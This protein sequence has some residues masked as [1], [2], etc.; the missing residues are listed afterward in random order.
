[1]SARLAADG[2][3]VS[4]LHADRLIGYVAGEQDG[5]VTWEQ[6]EDIG[7]RRGAIEHR[8]RRG[9]LHARHPRVFSWGAWSDS[10]W[11]ASRAAVFAC[12]DG[13]FVSRHA[14]L[15]LYGIRP[16]P[17]GPVDVTVIGRRVRQ[18]G[19]AART[20][21]ALDRRDVRLVRSIPVVSL[22]RA[23]LDAAPQL[24]ARELGDAVE[25]A[26][27]KRLL[28]KA[29]LRA[30]L[31]RAGARAGV[32]ALRALLDEA[33][34]TRS[35]AERILLELLRA[36]RL[37]EPV[38][39]AHVEGLEVDALWQRERVVLEFD[40]YAFHAT[41]AAFERDR[42]R[43]AR[44]QRARHVVLRTTWRELTRESHA[45]VARTAQELA[46]AR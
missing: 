35:R 14:A 40:S 28:T 17:S 20:T 9:L 31:D 19:I 3:D 29:E 34:F 41:R 42:G 10:Q 25:Q 8:V 32:A 33:A 27:V 13:A 6:L 2:I 23:L 7:L 11:A 1:V 38:F 5:L 46:R 12:G 39:N 15:G 16:H 30:T 45:L 37:P 4:K 18:Q 24:S 26:Q 36:A 44:L 43:T 22:A 21:A